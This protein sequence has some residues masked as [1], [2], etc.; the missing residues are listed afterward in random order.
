ME[1]LVFAFEQKVIQSVRYFYAILNDGNRCL[2][3]NKKTLLLP[4]CKTCLKENLSVERALSVKRC[5]YCGKELISTVNSC[6]RCREE[7]VITH[8]DSVWP[9]F[10]YRL[11]NKELL[12]KWKIQGERCL[13]NLFS[14]FVFQALKKLDYKII[15]PVPPRKGKIRKN[16]WDQINDLCLFLEKLYGY[17]VLKLL[18]RHSLKQQKKLNREER[19]ETIKS[20]YSLVP[21]K[22]LSKELKKT[23]GNLPAEVCLLDDVCTTGATIEACAKILKEVGIEKV[24]VITLFIVD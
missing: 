1:N 11:W 19:L 21:Q 10:S 16:G 5:K 23:G 4:L 13:T 22:K 12:F 9:L 14:N 3:C 8:C 17:K 2:I 20:A 15:V 24:N 7:P 6:M 18:D